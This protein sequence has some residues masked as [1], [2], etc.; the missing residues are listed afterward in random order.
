MVARALTT[1]I[2]ERDITRPISDSSRRVTR[3]PA[4]APARGPRRRQTR[5]A[6]RWRPAV[7][8]VGVAALVAVVAIPALLGHSASS[9]APVAD[10][11]PAYHIVYRVTTGSIVNTEDLWVHRPFESEDTIYGGPAATGAPISSIVNRLGRQLVKTGGSPGVFEPSPAPTPFDMRIDA[12]ARAAAANHALVVRGHQTVAGRDCQIYRTAQPLVSTTLTGRP[13]TADHVDSCIDRQGL[14]LSERRVQKGRTVQTRQAASVDLGA[15]AANHPFA[16]SGT[17]M[18]LKQ[19][20]GAVV[21]IND[22]SRPPGTD[23]WQLAAPPSGYTHFGRFAVVPP[24]PPA[25][26]PVVA[27]KTLVT[28]VDDVYVAG[29]DTIVI[30]QGQTAGGAPLKPPIGGTGVDAGRLGRALYVA[31]HRGSYCSD[32]VL[33]YHLTDRGVQIED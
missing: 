24:Q 15:A 14:L 1:A 26:D 3:P 8:I 11:P 10:V 32:E 28:A 12:V 22:D 13:T 16:T 4:P 31:K 30:E 25:D 7:A 21:T 17:H 29:A 27:R 9:P 23:F 20:G 5:Q 18:P 19:G 6:R 33:P 2:E